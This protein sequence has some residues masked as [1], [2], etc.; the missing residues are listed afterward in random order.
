MKTSIF[1]QKVW[2]LFS[3]LLVCSSLFISC[4]PQVSMKAG[5]NDEIAFVFSTGFSE[6]TAKTLKNL[7]GLAADAP[8]F[9]R[10][11]ILM[12]LQSAGAVNTIA[13][14]PSPTEI[15]ATGSFKEFSKNQL[16]QIGLIKRSENS[17]SLTVGPKQIAAF[18]GLLSEDS[19]SYLDL[20]MIPALLGEKMTVTEYRELLASMYGPS[21]ADEIV[22][23]KLTINISSP[24]GKKTLKE[25]V[26][27]G[28]LLCAVEEKSWVLSF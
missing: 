12:V 19:K 3:A 22:K 27:L 26:S 13:L 1:T 23:G 17:L 11:D 25:N 24:D 10:E 6:G 5:N 8:L 4:L 20:M 18:Y 7:S 15:A 28:D 21:F 2:G 14:I 16:S 9:N